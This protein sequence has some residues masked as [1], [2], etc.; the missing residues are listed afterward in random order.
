VPPILSVMKQRVA[1][2]GTRNFGNAGAKPD[3]GASTWCGEPGF[4]SR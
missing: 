4:L 1:A 2:D 3:A